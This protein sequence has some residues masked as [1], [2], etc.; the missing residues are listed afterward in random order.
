MVGLGVFLAHDLLG[1]PLP[2]ALAELADGEDVRSLARAVYRHLPDESPD[3]NLGIKL[4]PFHLAMRERLRDRARYAAAVLLAPSPLDMEAV[5][6]PP[7]LYP[8]YFAVRP[9]RL[10]TSHARALLW[11]RR[12]SPPL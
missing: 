7:G 4:A 11:S 8:L 6:L 5:P 3:P 1:A 12:S 9:V 10:A 2:E